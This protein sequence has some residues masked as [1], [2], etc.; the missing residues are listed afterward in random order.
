MYVVPLQLVD[1]HSETQSFTVPNN[2]YSVYVEILSRVIIR[3]MP[4]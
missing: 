2:I 1:Y 4:Y 3:N